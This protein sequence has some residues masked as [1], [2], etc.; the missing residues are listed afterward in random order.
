MKFRT[1]IFPVLICFACSIQST[2][3]QCLYYPVSL[4]QRISKS[5]YIVVGTVTEKQAYVDET[6]GNIQTLN[7]LQ[8]TAWLKNRQQTS[9]IYIITQGGVLGNR[10]TKVWPSLQLEQQMEYMLFLD[11]ENPQTGNKAMRIASPAALQVMAY[12]DAEGAL[13]LQN[14]LYHDLLVEPPITEEQLFDKVQL[15]TGQPV[16]TP[17]GARFAPRV[18]TGVT[19]REEGVTA[20]TS[21]SPATANAG[22]IISGDY[23]T[24]TGSGFGTTRGNVYFS[25]ADNGGGTTIAPQ[26]AS[27]YLSWSDNSITVKVP[28][29]A[30]TGR[31][32]VNGSISSVSPLTIPYAHLSIYNASVNFANVTR[33][34]YYLRNK[35]GNGGYTFLYN[36]SFNNNS[37]AVAAFERALGTW[38]CATGV[39]FTSGGTTTIATTANDGVNTI[40]FDNS[41]ALPAIG[42]TT[43]NFLGSGISGSCDQ[44]NTVW[45]A[46]DIDIRFRAD[47]PTGSATWNYGPGAP[48][49]SQI[50]FESVLLHEL[51]HAHGLG[52][53]IAPG[54][55]MHYAT[56]IGNNN[57]TLSANDIAGANAKMVYSTV[58][59]C[60]N[61]SGSGTPMTAIAAAGCAAMPFL[62]VKFEG[63]RKNDNTNTLVWTTAQESTNAAFYIQRSANGQ[64]YDD[65]GLVSSKGPSLQKLD[66]TFDDEQAGPKGWYYRLKQVETNGKTVVSTAIYLKGIGAGEWRIWSNTSGRT[67]FV[68]GSSNGVINLFSSSGQLIY[69]GRVQTGVTPISLNGLATGVYF[70]RIVTPSSTITQKVLIR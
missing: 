36:T 70:C 23:L 66:Y 32:F 22:T 6:T 61:P 14:G 30:G 18:T 64:L 38:R 69:T 8:I 2:Y 26:F 24:I 15:L 59:T 27:D 51:G 21:F 28:E 12:A 55:V 1:L 43:T 25:N 5:H 53:V 48:T 44:E 20:V 34:R 49:S 37:A 52:H 57:R 42:Q 7:R 4:E 9:S 10:A 17:A 50:D 31:F 45:W 13:P 3:S 41:L 19:A 63:N 60:F 29:N 46:T 68:S 39:N 35:N 33:Q 56:I 54:Q 11:K 67:L 40:F 58:P 62:L 16:E 65:I 47:P